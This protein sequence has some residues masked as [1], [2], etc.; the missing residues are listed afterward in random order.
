MRE[1]ARVGKDGVEVFR[2]VLVREREFCPGYK[3]VS[4]CVVRE[5]ADDE[6]IPS[7]HVL[8]PPFSTNNTRFWLG[9]ALP[10]PAEESHTV[11]IL[12]APQHW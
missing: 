2:A 5:L 9:F 10:L 6:F 7:L 8:T 4:S 11:P 12:L 3:I 1:R